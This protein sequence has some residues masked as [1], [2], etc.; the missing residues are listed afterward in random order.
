MR[1]RKRKMPDRI[2]AIFDRAESVSF[3]KQKL[4]YVRSK[5]WLGFNCGVDGMP[6]VGIIGNLSMRVLTQLRVEV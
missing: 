1:D 4:S 5:I 6:A 3:R 2:L